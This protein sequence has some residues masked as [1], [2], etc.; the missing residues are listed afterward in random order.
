MRATLNPLF[1]GAMAGR[2]MYVV[3]F[4]MGPLGSPIAHIGVE[5]SD[6]AY[7][8]VNMKIMT[9]MGKGAIDVLARAANS[10][11]ACRTVGALLAAGQA[12][13]ARPCNKTKYIVHF[14]ETRDL[15]LRLGL[16]RQ[17]AAR[18]EVLRAAHRVGDGPRRLAGR[19]HADPRRHQSR[20]A[21]IPRAAAFPSACGKTNFAM[22]IPPKGF[23]GWKVTTIG[24]DI[25]WIK[26]G[27]DGP[28]V[29]HQPEAGSSAW[30]RAPTKSSNANCMAS[31]AA[32]SIFT[33]VALT[34]DGDV[35]G[36]A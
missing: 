12:D 35:G 17:R 8:A 7:V 33:N 22:L 24:D 15:E 29:R 26:P 19:A 9:R 13:V 18:Q 27:K 16:R 1:K 34:D 11:P 14:P 31:L 28:P 25:A 10:C 5:L 4:S 21:E 20:R 32:M 6:S 3:P 30:R 23:E 36:K 2:T